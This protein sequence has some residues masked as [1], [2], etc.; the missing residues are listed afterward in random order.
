M[1]LITV[2]GLKAFAEIRDT[3]VGT[4]T[5]LDIIVTSVSARIQTYLNR[6]LTLANYTEHFNAGYG[7]KKFYVSAY[8]IVI[9][10]DRPFILTDNGS[11]MTLNSDF[12]L[13]E[14]EGLIEMNTAP[15]FI[16]PNQIKVVYY[17]G[18][19]I[20]DDSTSLN[21]GTLAVPDD[22]KLAVYMQCSYMY[23]RRNDLGLTSINIGGGGFSIAKMPAVE[24]LPE[25][26]SILRNFRHVPGMY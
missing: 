21:D 24:L 22:I 16:V 5:L 10:N 17:G 3:S 12:F 20:I 9:D 8:P 25:V 11:Q 13:R 1:K 4:A 15:V 7:R 26:K 23:K 19:P 18:Y 2:D 6:N 14:D